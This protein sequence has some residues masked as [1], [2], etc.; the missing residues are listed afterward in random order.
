MDPITLRFA[1]R[2][3][4]VLFGGMAIYLGYRLF[5]QVPERRGADGRL[6]LPWDISI[7]LTRVGPGVFFA[8]FGALVVGTSLVKGIEWRHAPV[9]GPVAFHGAGASLTVPDEQARD[10]ARVELLRDIAL[11]N[12]FPAYLRGNLPEQDRSTIET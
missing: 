12:N 5:L 11:L 2:L 10:V 1:E 9:D 4:A 7:V 6:A 8:L 3:V